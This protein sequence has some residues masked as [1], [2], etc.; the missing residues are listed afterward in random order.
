MLE[1]AGE[2][3]RDAGDTADRDAQFA[4]VDSAGPGGRAGYVEERL[5]RIE[6]DGDVAVG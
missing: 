4:I 6:R 5:L 2:V 3:A 1:D